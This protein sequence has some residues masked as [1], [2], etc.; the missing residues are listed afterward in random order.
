MPT[1]H[2]R[3]NIQSQCAI[4]AALSLL[5][6]GSVLSIVIQPSRAAADDVRSHLPE[7]SPEWNPKGGGPMC[8]VLSACRAARLVGVACTPEDYVTKYY[9][10]SAQGSTPDEVAAVVRDVGAEPRILSGMSILE[11]RGLNGPIIA[12]VRRS[13]ATPQYD[14]WVVAIA[15]DGGVAV[16]DGAGQATRTTAAEFLGIWSGLGVCVTGPETQ[17]NG[18]S[19]WLGRLL[20]LQIG[21][22][23]AGIMRSWGPRVGNSLRSGMVLIVSS[24][25][26][27]M[28]VGLPLLAGP[29]NFWRG[30][31]VAMA[32][33]LADRFHSGDLQT[34]R[35]ASADPKCL[36]IDARLESDYRA[37][38]LPRAIN[39]PVHASIEQIR[40]FLQHVDRGTPLVVFCQSSACS[41]DETIG[42][43]LTLLG[44]RNVTVT[45]PGYLEFVSERERIDK[46]RVSTY[47]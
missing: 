28:A 12:N 8:G 31:N 34:L 19:L 41:Y 4:L 43:Q 32:P 1:R 25:V 27:M 9:V 14:H 40:E 33:F 15:H 11:L 16:L 45:V 29:A 23:F 5:S 37:G 44:F 3:P 13:P 17:V 46:R 47:R 36:L 24:S 7:Q 21:V 18:E 2:L 39:I 35:S 26:A 20:L 22:A 10:G 38:S 42:R 30:S 6:P